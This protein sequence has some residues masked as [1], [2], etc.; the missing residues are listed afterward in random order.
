[1]LGNMARKLNKPQLSQAPFCINPGNIEQ[2]ERETRTKYTAPNLC[3]YNEIPHWGT[4][5]ACDGDLVTL[6]ER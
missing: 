4:V 5:V 1:M 3:L 6:I 2:S